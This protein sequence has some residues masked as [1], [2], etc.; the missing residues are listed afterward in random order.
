MWVVVKIRVPFWVPI[1]IRHLLFKVPKMDHNFDN[2]P[3]GSHLWHSPGADP[4][5][6]PRGFLR[7]TVTLTW[8]VNLAGLRLISGPEC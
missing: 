8:W 4:T 2:H 1:I 3:C 7:F 5:E 6:R